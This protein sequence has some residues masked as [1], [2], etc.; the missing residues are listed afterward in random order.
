MVVIPGQHIY[1]SGWTDAIE[2]LWVLTCWDWRCGDL[3]SIS[4]WAS[5][6][7]LSSPEKGE[8]AWGKGD[9]LPIYVL[10]EA[11]LFFSQEVFFL[12]GV[13]AGPCGSDLS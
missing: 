9:D 3:N 8:R 10:K 4:I 13:L 11:L 2:R 1:T 6:V 7:G 12:P 5:V